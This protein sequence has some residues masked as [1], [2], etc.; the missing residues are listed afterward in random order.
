MEEEADEGFWTG[1][2]PSLYVWIFL[3]SSESE[4]ATRGVESTVSIISAA[5]L[6]SGGTTQ[7]GHNSEDRR[8]K[9]D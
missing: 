8:K 3:T 7:L 5:T 6:L 2:S 1:S 4:T 9:V